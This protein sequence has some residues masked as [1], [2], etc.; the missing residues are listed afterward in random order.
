MFWLRI[1]RP[2]LSRGAQ[3]ARFSTQAPLFRTSKGSG[4]KPKTSNKP[5]ATRFQKSAASPTETPVDA[6]LEAEANQAE[7]VLKTA[8]VSSPTPVPRPVRIT[9]PGLRANEA[10]RAPKVVDTSSKEYKRAE[11]KVT[12]VIVALPIAMVTSYFLWDRLALGHM[13]PGQNSPV[14][15][16]RSP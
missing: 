7:P 9:H 16:Q 13:P 6:M 1:A 15:P 11:R 2:P 12:S 3:S 10:S 5:Q 4:P 8:A 14:A